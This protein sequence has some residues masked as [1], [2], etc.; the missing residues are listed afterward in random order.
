MTF[1]PNQKFIK[2]ELFNVS[3]SILKLMK[4]D[5]EAHKRRKRNVKIGSAISSLL[6][7]LKI[8]EVQKLKFLED[9]I[10]FFSEVE[11]KLK[12]KKVLLNAK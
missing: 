8:N 9:C 10:N 4:L 6:G 11:S 12:E 3:K 7:K 1:S 2:K 5:S